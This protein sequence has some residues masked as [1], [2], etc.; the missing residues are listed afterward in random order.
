VGAKRSSFD[1]MGLLTQHNTRWTLS[2]YPEN[3]I[4]YSQGDLADSVF[5]IHQ[6]KVKVTVISER[7]KELIEDVEKFHLPIAAGFSIRRRLRYWKRRLMKRGRR[8]T[9]MV[10]RSGGANLRGACSV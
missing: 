1:V 7:G 2:N 3:Q 9:V 5:Y 10:T 4:V 6:G 8:W